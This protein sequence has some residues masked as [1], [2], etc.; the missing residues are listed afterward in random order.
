LVQSYL[1]GLDLS[2]SL[3]G[4]GG[5]G[6]LLAITTATNDTHFFA[7]D[8]NGNVVALVDADD[9][10]VSAVYD[11]DP[12]GNELRATG[13]MAKENLL[14]F[15]T[16]FADAVTGRPKYLHREYDPPTGR[17]LCRDPI[18]E[19]GGLN[20]YGF[21]DNRPVLMCDFLGFD[22]IQEPAA[23]FP[24][25]V[26]TNCKGD[27]G[28]DITDSLD[29][30][31]RDIENGFHAARF[32]E[33]RK[34]CDNLYKYNPI[35]GWLAWD[36]TDI[37]A[38]GAGDLHHKFNTDCGIQSTGEGACARSFTFSGTCIYASAANYAMWGKMFKLCGLMPNH[39]ID[40]D[41]YSLDTA[42]ALGRVWKW[43]QGDFRADMHAQVEAFVKYGYGAGTPEFGDFGLPC[44]E[45]D[46]KVEDK[47]NWT[48]EPIRKRN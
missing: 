25:L 23:D 34:A 20:P 12:F 33:K 18:G 46:C 13:P 40:P 26:G 45:S 41:R 32:R 2:G 4:A 48:W 7:F 27:C 42:I 21:V 19:D 8:G 22:I 9:G 6:G 10:S 16:Q 39:P 44:R 36:L 3:Q 47:L 14:R 30:V 37:Y 29:R 17:W 28:P 31:L 43:W 35:T 11:Y 5:V 24:L 38:A 15:S 1:R